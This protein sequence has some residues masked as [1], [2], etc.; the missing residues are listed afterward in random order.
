M[1]EY[2]EEALLNFLKTAVLFILLVAAGFYAYNSV[3][4][5]EQKKAELDKAEKKLLTFIP[6]DLVKIVVRGGGENFT[7]EKRDGQ[8]L[9]VSPI[10]TQA[11]SSQ[12]DELMTGVAKGHILEKVAGMDDRVRFGLD[13]AQWEFEF[14]T[15]QS[16]SPQK[17]SIGKLSPT[18]KVVYVTSSRHDGVVAMDSGFR[19]RVQKPM[20]FLREK[21]LFDADSDEIIKL[22]LVR[23]GSRMVAEKSETG[24]WELLEPF[25]A[26][27]D[28]KKIG[29][30]IRKTVY[31]RAEAFPKGSVSD[32]VTS[33]DSPEQVRLW[34]RG[35]EKPLVLSLGGKSAGGGLLWVRASKGET[36]ANVKVG[37]LDLVPA[38][39]RDLREMRIFPADDSFWDELK[40][41]TIENGG[42]TISLAKNES[43]VW[44]ALQPSS[45]KPDDDKIAELLYNISVMKS[46]RFISGSKAGL[47]TANLKIEFTS[48][49]KKVS[50]AFLK[51]EKKQRVIGSSDFHD[52]NFEVSM[53]DFDILDARLSDIDNRRLFSIRANEV[54]S[55]SIKS[56]SLN[57]SFVKEKNRWKSVSPPGKDLDAKKF[58]ALLR[59]LARAEC[60]GL[61][62]D[63]G[64]P[65]GGGVLG[66]V[67]MS[68]REGKMKR[69]LTLL[70]YNKD[71]SFVLATLEGGEALLK[72]ST[73]FAEV[74]SNKELE[75][76][77]Q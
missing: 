4:V 6:D 5:E 9:I 64:E 15:S 11:D 10:E 20:F 41:L 67:T 12:L 35:I 77:F 60:I 62:V 31:I 46:A 54:V 47:K 61:A 76:L 43:D 29:E 45:F 51:S 7:I 71:K 36:V 26:M 13:P 63:D 48:G 16:A 8:W 2:A 14:Y 27:A 18:S 74:I 53:P 50:I 28:G 44:R 24:K 65:T 72:I 23:G 1:G 70:G 73:T 57:Y 22:E 17:L 42:K 30:L 40:E 39:A 34:R 32:E 66:V 19:H 68:A 59:Y 49:E 52:K 38:D 25:K 58:E 69:S 75:E 55:L 21:R 56:E 3:H 37:Y 33:L